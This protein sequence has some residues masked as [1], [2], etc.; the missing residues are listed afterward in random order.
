MLI[1]T[2]FIVYLFVVY[3]NEA[4]LKKSPPNIQFIGFYLEERKKSHKN[5]R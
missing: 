1:V 3:F 2:V 4:K 5:A